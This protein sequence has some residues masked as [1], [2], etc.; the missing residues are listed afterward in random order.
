MKKG[1]T[2]LELLIVVIIVAVLASFAIPQYLTS[3]EKGKVAKAKNALS[4]IAKAEKMYRAE[5]DVYCTS[6][7]ALNNYVDFQAQTAADPD[8]AYT[9]PAAGAS[10]FQVRATRSAGRYAGAAGQVDVNENNT[11]GGTHPFA[12]YK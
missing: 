12:R 11:W 4:L 8:W 7:T 1:F 9:I 6:Q 3:V 10:S 5:M 2:L